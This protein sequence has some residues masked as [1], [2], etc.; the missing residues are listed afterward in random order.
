MS[1]Q[2][3][4]TYRATAAT[5]THVTGGSGGAPGNELL[6]VTCQTTTGWVRIA[7]TP[8]TWRS[9]MQYGAVS[10]TGQQQPA[11]QQK[12]GTKRARFA[13]RSLKQARSSRITTVASAA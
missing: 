8:P 9:L 6:E 12:A 5:L 7:F 13:P 4:T 3:L 2:N 10:G 1:A 11:Q